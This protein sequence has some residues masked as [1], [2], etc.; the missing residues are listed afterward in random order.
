[1]MMAAKDFL[2]Y[3][4]VGLSA[5]TI[6]STLALVRWTI[7]KNFHFMDRFITAIENRN[8]GEAED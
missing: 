7:S 6:L 4:V 8:S 1:M 3:G 2:D 5:L